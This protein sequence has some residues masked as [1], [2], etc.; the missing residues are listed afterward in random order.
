MGADDGNVWT[1]ELISQPGFFL[2]S[3]GDVI[4]FDNIALVSK[5]YNVYLKRSSTNYQIALSDED[6]QRLLHALGISC[7]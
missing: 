5:N 7:E 2:T 6:Y 4:P 3:D 1:S